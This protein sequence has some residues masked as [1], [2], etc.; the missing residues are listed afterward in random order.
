MSPARF[1]SL[2]FREEERRWPSHGNLTKSFSVVSQHLTT[3]FDI[4]F[5]W[6]C[7]YM[8]QLVLPKFPARVHCWNSVH[9]PHL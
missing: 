5:F 8:P 9:G 3:P 1:D 6:H 7:I 2:K 4:F